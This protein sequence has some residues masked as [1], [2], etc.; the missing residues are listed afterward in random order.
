MKSLVCVALLG[1]ATGLAW[2][3]SEPILTLVPSTDTVT[4]GRNVTVQL[5]ISGLGSMCMPVQCMEVGAFDVFLGFNPA[6]LTPTGVNFTLLLGDPNLFQAIT[7][8]TNGSHWVEATDLSLL[9]KQE[10]DDLQKSGAFTLATYSFTALESGHIDFS[11]L[12]GPVVNADGQL[13]A[14]T[15]S[16]ALPEPSGIAVVLTGVAAA[17]GWRRFR[18]GGVPRLWQKL[19]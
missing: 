13:I 7:A 16:P 18:H 5:D 4:A 17:G 6:L 19:R 1:L 15:L 11:N 8:I 14:G 2:A 12:G 10:L 9:T 3:G